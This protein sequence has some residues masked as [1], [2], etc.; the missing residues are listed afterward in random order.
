METIRPSTKY[1]ITL[2]RTSCKLRFIINN[3]KK[4][5]YK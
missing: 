2:L 1:L 3:K 4:K 5:I